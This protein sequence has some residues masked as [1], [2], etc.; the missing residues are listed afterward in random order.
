MKVTRNK[1]QVLGVETEPFETKS[2]VKQ[3]DGMSPLIFCFVLEN[4]IREVLERIKDRNRHTIQILA[5]A[6]DIVLLK[7]N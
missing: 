5:F 6:N 2:G 3:V 1:V 4:T 7:R